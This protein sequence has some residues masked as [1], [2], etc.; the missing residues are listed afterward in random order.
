MQAEDNQCNED[1]IL[2]GPLA[3]TIELLDAHVLLDPFEKQL[4]RPPG[5]VH[6][7]NF[8]SV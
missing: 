8:Y 3:L 1:L 7:G 6:L 2:N 4:D 5:P